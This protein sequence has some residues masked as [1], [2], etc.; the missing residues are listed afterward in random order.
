MIPTKKMNVN[1]KQGDIVVCTWGL[2]KGVKFY[3]EKVL[4]AGYSCKRCD[5]ENDRY[6]LYTDSTLELV[7]Y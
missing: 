5:L 7:K 6:H 4:P 1:F 2:N 3:I